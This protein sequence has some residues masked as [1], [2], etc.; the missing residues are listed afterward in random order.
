MVKDKD[1]NADIVTIKGVK[2]I[3]FDDTLAVPAWKLRELLVRSY[4]RWKRVEKEK[5]A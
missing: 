1:V 4:T 5:K 2:F 3:V